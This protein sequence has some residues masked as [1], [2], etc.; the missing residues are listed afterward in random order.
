MV[1]LGLNWGR[2]AGNRRELI[3]PLGHIPTNRVESA[4][5]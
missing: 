3:H 4:R 2:I 5:R 1:A